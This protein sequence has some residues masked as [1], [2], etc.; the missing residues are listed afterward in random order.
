MARKP[1]K[2]SRLLLN[3]KHLGDLLYDKDKKGRGYLK[4]S[5]KNK[6]AGFVR[7]SDVATTI[8][9]PQPLT[10][11]LR[12]ELSYKFDENF[13]SVKKIFDGRKP[14]Y[15]FYKFSLPPKTCL[16]FLRIKDWYSLDD[17][18]GDSESSLVLPTPEEKSI[19]VIFSFIGENG[20]PLSPPKYSDGMMGCI[21]LPEKELNKFCIGATVDPENNE[22]NN[23]LILF[24]YIK[25]EQIR[26]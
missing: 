11:Q 15:E 5:F 25:V 12:L 18:S 9:T 10:E 17:N 24:P 4:L 26:N 22:Q 2:K 1:I 8:P 13:F 6:I 19:A 16:F 23:I 21:D 3:H 14:E 7:A 20:Q